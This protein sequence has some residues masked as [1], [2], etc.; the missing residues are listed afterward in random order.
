VELARQMER[1]KLLEKSMEELRKVIDRD[2]Q[3]KRLDAQDAGK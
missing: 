2:Q 3:R 1:N